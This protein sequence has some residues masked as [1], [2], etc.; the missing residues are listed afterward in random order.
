MRILLL[1]F[2]FIYSFNVSIFSQEYI[3]LLQEDN[4]W[5]FDLNVFNTNGGSTVSY[6]C[7]I[8]NTEIINGQEY[9]I[10]T[11]SPYLDQSSY[12]CK[13]RE[14]EGVVYQYNED[15]NLDE[16]LLDFN[17]EIGD[18]FD[19][20]GHCFLIPVGGYEDSLE[21]IDINIEFIA[22][23][24][25]KVLTLRDSFNWEEKWIEGIGSTFG[26]GPGYGDPDA[27][28]LLSCFTKNGITTLFNGAG[29]CDNTFL[30]L[31]DITKDKVVL[32]H[33]PITTVSVLQ[34]P[35]SI[36]NAI[37]KYY[38]LTGNLIQVKHITSN[39]V[40]IIKDDFVAGMY[41]YQ[42]ESED[43]VE[44]SGKFLVK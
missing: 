39:E 43:K 19:Y 8:T 27:F 13:L 25:R 1:L 16:I 6:E 22:G 33:N 23:E 42:I 24:D 26:I 32:S 9:S 15:L 20:V 38:D 28:T 29:A 14:S 44:Y 36:Q 41:F 35:Q 7:L 5:S 12:D 3:P 2:L 18:I 11:I 37:I 31:D 17:L 40:H 30:R 21:V 4:M 34:L 10:V